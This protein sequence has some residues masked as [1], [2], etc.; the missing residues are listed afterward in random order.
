MILALLFD[1]L[2]GFHD[3]ANSIA[4][5]VVT[6]TLTPFQA[7]LLAGLANFVGYFAFSHAIAKMVSSG[8]INL[9]SMPSPESKMLLLLGALVAMLPAWLV[10]RRPIAEGLVSA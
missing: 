7:V 8:I 10:F 5:V 4:T 1:F 9:D 2:N 3:A 6:R